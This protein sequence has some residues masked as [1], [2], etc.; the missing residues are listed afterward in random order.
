M[1]LVMVVEH[2]RV[3]YLQMVLVLSLTYIIILI[4]VV[5]QPAQQLHLYHVARERQGHLQVQTILQ[6][7][8]YNFVL[9]QLQ[10][11]L[12]QVLLQQP[13]LTLI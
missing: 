2:M 8:I 10:R 7:H 3:L 11:V 4:V 6:V 5:Y 9:E 12:K 1:V 13:R